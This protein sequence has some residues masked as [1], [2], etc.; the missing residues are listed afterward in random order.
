MADLVVAGMHALGCMLQ[1]VQGALA[2]QRRTILAPC[3]QFAGQD[4]HC[5]IVTKLV[6]VDQILIAQGDA[7]DTLPNQRPHLMFDQFGLPAIVEACSKT[8]HQT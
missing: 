3:L 7:E 1:P 8:I 2:R 6:M 4:R 5:R